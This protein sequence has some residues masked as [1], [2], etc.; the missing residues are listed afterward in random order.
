MTGFLDSNLLGCLVLQSMATKLRVIYKVKTW[1]QTKCLKKIVR[2][3]SSSLTSK[4]TH[5][6]L[7]RR[8][9]EWKRCIR[10]RQLLQTPVYTTNSLIAAVFSSPAT[11]KT[12]SS[13]RPLSSQTRA[14]RSSHSQQSDWQQL[15]PERS[16][17]EIRSI[18]TCSKKRKTSLR[19]CKKESKSRQIYHYQ[20]LWLVKLPQKGQVARYILNQLIK[21][22]K[23]VLDRQHLV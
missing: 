18:Q 10:R 3:L 22:S 21:K 19:D 12:Q 6:I 9:Q 14:A 23:Q 15:S 17:T 5:I 20:A 2:H 11:P 13:W 1:M 4:H 16:K 7:T 8:S